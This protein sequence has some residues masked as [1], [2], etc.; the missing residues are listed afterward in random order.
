MSKDAWINGFGFA[1]LMWTALFFIAQ[2]V[3]WIV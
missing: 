2:I 3:R 1:F